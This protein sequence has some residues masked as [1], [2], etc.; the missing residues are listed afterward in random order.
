MAGD[1]TKAANITNKMAK[2]L[3]NKGYI[4]VTKAELTEQLRIIDGKIKLADKLGAD[5]TV[6]ELRAFRSE[7]ID[8]VNKD[9]SIAIK[10]LKDAEEI[11]TETAEFVTKLM[12]TRKGL[13]GPEDFKRISEIMSKNLSARAP[14]TDKFIQ[15]WKVVAK[16]Y[17]KEA[18]KV[19]IPWVTFDGKI[20]TQRY[21]PKLQER[22]EFRDPVS[23]RKVMNIYLAEAENGKLLGKGSLADASIGLGVN[24]NHSND[25]VIVR[26]FHLWGLKNNVSTGTIHDAFFTNIGEADNARTALRNIYAD[27]LEGDTIRKTLKEM[28]KQGMSRKSYYELL[29]RAKELGLIDPENA[30]T[31]EDILAPIPEGMDWYGIGP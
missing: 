29:N 2:V 24:G 6:G 20:M 26:R 18:E 3:E 4:T 30:L 19:D 21:R 1:A 11:S 23:G 27:A 16:T 31:R 12:N 15:F 8:M 17:V 10:L 7:L 22:I 5:I 13:V 9:Q 28:Q 25:A 14:V